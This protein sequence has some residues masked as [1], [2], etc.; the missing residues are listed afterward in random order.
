MTRTVLAQ[1]GEHRHTQLELPDPCDLPIPPA[2]A[3]RVVQ[4]GATSLAD[5][6]FDQLASQFMEGFSGL[7]RT[8]MT[9]WVDFPS[10]HLTSENGLSPALTQI[11]SYTGG[12]QVLFLTAGILFAGA[13]LALAKRGGVASEAQESFLML[14]RAVFGAMTFAAVIAA[15]TRAGDE[16][17]T[18]VILDAT[19]GDVTA[20]LIEMAEFDILEGGS[21]LGTGTALIVGLLGLISTLVQLV[22]LVIRQALL[23]VVVAVLP[24]AAAASGTGP[25]SQGFKRLLAWSLA[26]VLW[27][28]TGA[29]IYALAFTVAGD[30]HQDPQ[31]K[32]LGLILLVLSVVALP[33]L[34]RLVSPAVAALGGGGGA[35]SVLAGGAAGVAMSAVGNRSGAR[36]VSEGEHAAGPQGTNPS[37]GSSGPSGGGGRPMPEGGGGSPSPSGQQG[38]QA[39]A[40]PAS[41]TARSAGTSKQSPGA[42]SNDRQTSTAGTGGGGAGG[43]AG[44]AMAAKA[45]VDLAKQG[46]SALD[47]QVESAVPLDPDTLGSGEVRR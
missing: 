20:L 12:L 18:W 15:A 31:L 33:A 24:I 34:I 41:G 25:G 11:R 3:C 26:F 35:S 4:E 29:L 22:M 47:R 23:I 13:R 16:F 10:P 28:P 27:K 39:A 43:A 45:G 32:L 44:V 37:S 1:L 6:A 30:D 40:A 36:K 2:L 9:W 7:L 8:V 5:S 46:T 38:G 19:R 21:G 17:A 14:A 42:V